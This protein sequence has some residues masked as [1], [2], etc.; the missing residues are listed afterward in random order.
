MAFLTTAT[1]RRVFAR[2]NHRCVVGLLLGGQCHPT[3]H[4][5]H[6]VPRSEGGSDDDENLVSVCARHHPRWERFRRILLA[7]RQGAWKRCPHKHRSAESRASC[8]A[9]L[10]RL[11][12]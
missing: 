1:R 7:E 11:A 4:V 5:H 3:L 2:D 8:E 10:N 9:R 12:A 6:I